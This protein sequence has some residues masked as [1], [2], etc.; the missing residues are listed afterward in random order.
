MQCTTIQYMVH[1]T[2]YYSGT[3]LYVLHPIWVLYYSS[4]PQ[5]IWLLYTMVGYGTTYRWYA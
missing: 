1:T 2:I 5:G 4:I 3:Q